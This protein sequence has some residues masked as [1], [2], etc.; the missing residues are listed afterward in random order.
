MDITCIHVQKKSV[1]SFVKTMMC[2]KFCI[3][4]LSLLNFAYAWNV[5]SFPIKP[6]NMYPILLD[7]DGILLDSGNTNQTDKREIK[8]FSLYNV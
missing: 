7:P 6:S 5:K 1:H 8:I 4:I 2:L 3:V